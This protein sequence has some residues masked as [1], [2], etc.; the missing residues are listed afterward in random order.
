V[1]ED[2]GMPVSHVENIP[3]SLK[4]WKKK[5]CADYIDIQ[6]SRQLC[7]PVA[8]VFGNLFDSRFLARC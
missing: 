5:R 2:N 3:L 8:E 6:E 4:N 1:G 7:P